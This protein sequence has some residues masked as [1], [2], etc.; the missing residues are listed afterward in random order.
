[1]KNYKSVSKPYRNLAN[2]IKTC[3]EK[4]N[5]VFN[6]FK[7]NLFLNFDQVQRAAIYFQKV[8]FKTLKG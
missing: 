3:D 8:R 1:M 2:I 5:H 6:N 4:L 7:F